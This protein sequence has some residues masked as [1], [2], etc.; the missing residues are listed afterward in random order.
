MLRDSLDTERVRAEYDAGALTLRIPIAERARRC[1]RCSRCS[2]STSPA[3]NA[4]SWRVSCP[5]RRGRSSPRGAPAEARWAAG[6]VL[7]A[8]GDRAGGEVNGRIL[9]ALPRGYALLF[10]RAELTPAA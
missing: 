9:A 6:T 4:V 5:S 8:V 10:G 1:S 3:R 2:A 7:I